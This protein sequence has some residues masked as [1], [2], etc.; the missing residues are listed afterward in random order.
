M[1]IAFAILAAMALRRRRLA[2]L[3]FALLV[4]AWV[5]LAVVSGAETGLLYL[6]P[7]LLLS[8]PL[9]VGRYLG[10][11]QLADLAKR[12][13]RRPAR[14]AARLA[15]PRSHVRLMQRGGRLVA[16]SLAKR[17]PPPATALLSA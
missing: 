15:V 9:I 12:S 11:E 16:S 6:A 14:C 10:E 7:A 2:L 13:P 17:P 3:W 4:S 5:V 1:V 8:A